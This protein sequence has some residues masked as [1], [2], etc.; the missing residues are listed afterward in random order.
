[1]LALM[2][3]L[4]TLALVRM[5]TITMAMDM[6]ECNLCVVVDQSEEGDDHSLAGYYRYYIVKE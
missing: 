6:V 2:L 3:Y 4:P 1:M 5:S